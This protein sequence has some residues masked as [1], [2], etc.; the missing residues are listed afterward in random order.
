MF[1]LTQLEDTFH[2]CVN[3]R[4]VFSCIKSRSFVQNPDFSDANS[5]GMLSGDECLPIFNSSEKDAC[6]LLHIGRAG[7]PTNGVWEI[8]VL[9]PQGPVLRTQKTKLAWFDC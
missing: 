4:A 7:R 6:S 3:C 2:R 5:G 8:S 1:L 9:Y